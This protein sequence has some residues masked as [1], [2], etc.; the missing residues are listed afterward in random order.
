MKKKKNG[1]YIYNEALRQY[2]YHTTSKY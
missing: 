1:E 2:K